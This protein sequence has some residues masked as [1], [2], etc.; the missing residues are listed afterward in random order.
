MTIVVKN[1]TWRQSNKKIY[2]TIPLRGVPPSKGQEIL[3]RVTGKYA[4]NQE[5]SN[6]RVVTK[7]PP[8]FCTLK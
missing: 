4:R 2:I 3:A 5:K 8:L 6:L 1:F 7:I